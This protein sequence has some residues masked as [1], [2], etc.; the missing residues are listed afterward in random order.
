[1]VER[2]KSLP[3]NR[4]LW[5]PRSSTLL[6]MNSINIRFKETFNARE[7]DW[8]KGV[9]QEPAYSKTCSKYLEKDSNRWKKRKFQIFTISVIDSIN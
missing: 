7:L 1:M 2:Q 4:I 5:I 9:F 6:W 3:M 8:L